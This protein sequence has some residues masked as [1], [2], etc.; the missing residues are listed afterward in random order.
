MCGRVFVTSTLEELL[1]AFGF[2]DVADIEAGDELNGSLPRWNAAPMQNYPIFIRY[3]DPETGVTGRRAVMAQWGLMPSW[4]DPAKSKIAP[5]VNAR[6]ETIKEK[7]SFRSA[8]KLRRCLVPINGYFEWQDIYSNGKNK[9]PHA[10]AMKSG[11]PFCLAGIWESWRDRETGLER[12]TFAIVTCPPNELIARIHDRMPVILHP[13]DY[14]RWIGPEPD[15]EDLMV[16]YPSDLM[17][18]W[19]I[20]RRVGKVQNNTPDI[21]DPEEPSDPEPPKPKGRTPKAP[22][23]QEPTLF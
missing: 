8:Y 16:P 14:A 10:I 1:F 2:N 21:L 19:P 23:D 6:C 22:K 15:P 3:D 17:T 13:E 11:K 7:A 5:Q 20:G 4:Y 18:R 9:Q 12:R